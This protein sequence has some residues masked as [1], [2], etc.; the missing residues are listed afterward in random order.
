[1]GYLSENQ[2]YENVQKN[3]TAIGKQ[4]S[5][6]CSSNFIPHVRKELKIAPMDAPLT[7][8]CF[9]CR[10]SEVHQLKMMKTLES[11][12]VRLGFGKIGRSKNQHCNTDY[13]DDL[14]TSKL[15]I[16]SHLFHGM[17][18]QVALNFFQ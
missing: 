9:L 17:I 15:L 14:N 4:A 13:E 3:E 6:K 16:I 12:S 1:M 18:V 7:A 5:D 8:W 2:V 11:G 10:P